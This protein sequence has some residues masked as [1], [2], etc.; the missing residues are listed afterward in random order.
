MI[1]LNKMCASDTPRVYRYGKGDEKRNTEREYA[2][3]G[4]VFSKESF[5]DRILVYRRRDCPD[6]SKAYSNE[7]NQEYL[8]VLAEKMAEQGKKIVSFEEYQKAVVLRGG[9]LK[10]FP[11]GQDLFTNGEPMIIDLFYDIQKKWIKKPLKK[12]DPI[13]C[14]LEIDFVR[15]NG[16][17]GFFVLCVFAK[18][19]NTRNV[20][21]QIENEGVDL[22]TAI[23]LDVLKVEFPKIEFKG[24]MMVIDVENYSAMMCEINRDVID[25][26]SIAYHNRIATLKAC[27][28]V[29]NYPHF[30]KIYGGK[31]G[32]IELPISKRTIDLRQNSTVW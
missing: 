8:T 2:T 29:K 14:R 27:E 24:Y 11:V 30:N 13:E 25:V 28:E 1:D 21:F 16:K 23:A 12:D 32:V 18:N 3:K 6:P 31:S 19:V 9:V 26:A 15:H 4:L 17:A 10:S 7:K 20:V 22:L 5:F